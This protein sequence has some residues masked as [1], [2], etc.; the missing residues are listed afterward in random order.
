MVIDL[1]DFEGPNS[2]EMSTFMVRMS[3][4]RVMSMFFIAKTFVE[5]RKRGVGF[6]QDLGVVGDESVV[7]ECSDLENQYQYFSNSLQIHCS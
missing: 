7:S 1:P 4:S 5:M 6:Y 3:P 2:F